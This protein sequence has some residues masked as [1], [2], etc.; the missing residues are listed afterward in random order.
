M[1]AE[2]EHLSQPAATQAI[3][4]LETGV[5]V[6][7]F[8]R[9]ADGFFTTGFGE[10]LRVRVDRAMALLE[11]GARDAARIGG[12]PRAR[13]FQR[14][15]RL[16]TASQLRALIAVVEARNYSLAARHIGISQPSIHRAARNLERV[17]G[18]KLFESAHDGIAPTPAA[19]LL[20]R[21]ARLAL[22]ELRQGLD[23]IDQVLE[24]D[25]TRI[26][27][28]TLPLARTFVLPTAIAALI[29]EHELVQVRAVDGRYDELLRSLRQGE[30]DCMIGALRDPAPTD[31]VVQEP[32]FEDPL[33]VVVGAGH[34][35]AGKRRIALADTLAYPWVAPPKSTPAGSYLYD[36]LRIGEQPRTPVRVVSSSLVLVRG[37]LARGNYITIISLQQIRYEL[38]HGTMLPLAIDLPGSER[39]IGLTYRRDWRATPTQTRFLD[40]LRAA[41]RLA[42][43]N[44]IAR[45]RRTNGKPRRL[46]TRGRKRGATQP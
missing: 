3:A 30:L 26:V 31:D 9:R 36:T 27:I 29:D 38:E 39:P 41:G 12:K 5:G 21:H 43:S 32:L 45:S 11:S 35:L 16:M 2:R 28:G 1:A 14:F 20:A 37:L 18:L 42:A 10:T 24:R 33:A 23:E 4:R 6:A 46:N 8:D 34:P 17:S 44:P 15:D 13:G 25:S 7:L 22:V 40:H 19:R